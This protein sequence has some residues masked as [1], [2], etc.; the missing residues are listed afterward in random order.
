M[1]KNKTKLE[2]HEMTYFLL[3]PYTHSLS[4]TSAQ[5]HLESIPS[6]TEDSTFKTGKPQL[7]YLTVQGF[8]LNSVFGRPVRF[9]VQKSKLAALCPWYFWCKGHEE[10]A[11]GDKNHYKAISNTTSSLQHSFFIS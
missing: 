7:Q 3:H 4:K 8:L 6:I 9:L 1:K 2:T 5:G 10:Q 11:S